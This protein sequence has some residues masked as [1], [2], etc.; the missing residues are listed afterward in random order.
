[1]TSNPRGIN[2][3]GSSPIDTRP[4]SSFSRLPHEGNGSAT[5]RPRIPRFASLKTNAGIEIQNCA[6]NTGLRFGTTWIQ[7][8]RLPPTPE[9]RAC[10][11]KSESRSEPAV[12][13]KT[14]AALVQPS[15]PNIKNVTS[16]DTNGE[17]FS[18][19]IA[20]TVISKNNHGS[21]TNRSV[22]AIAALAHAPPR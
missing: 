5:P 4:S 14:R 11:T 3:H 16:T 15:R 9:A 10:R 18:G 2:F 17:T 20:R 22:T 1:M 13:H 21:E 6:Y 8:S 19:I 7:N 12:A